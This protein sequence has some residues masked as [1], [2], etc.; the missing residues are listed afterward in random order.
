MPD[1]SDA[2]ESPVDDDGQPRFGLY[3]GRCA[4]TNL[5]NLSPTFGGS[6]SNRLLGEKSWHWFCLADRQIACSGTILSAGYG[7]TVFAWVFNRET[8]EMIVE[9]SGILPPLTAD[10][11]DETDG[12]LARLRGFRRSFSV[13]RDGR[14]MQISG[15]LG[16]LSFD[17]TLRETSPP[18]ITAICPVRRHNADPADDGGDDTPSGVNVTTKQVCLEASGRFSTGDRI[19]RLGEDAIGMTDRTHGLL[20]RHTQ[21]RWAIG[22]GHLDDGTPVGFNLVSDF[23]DCLENAVWIDDQVHAASAAAIDFDAARPTDPWHARTDDGRIDLSLG[24]E[25]VRESET[26][27]RVVT[28]DFVSPKGLW[29]GRLLDREVHSLY[30][31]AEDHRATW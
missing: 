8:H 24:V 4:T 3:R 7:G 27:L 11:R 17:V 29:E 6:A 5:D 28:S 25:G 12:V 10:L 21:W 13:E 14:K 22:S 20:G 2:P 1:I 30:G 15:D 31:V 19:F 18:P 16:D 26:D 23:N 9:A